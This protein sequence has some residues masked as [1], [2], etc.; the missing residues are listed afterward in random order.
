MK[1]TL[2]ILLFLATYIFANNDLLELSHKD[3]ERI[4]SY[5]KK[6]ENEELEEELKKG[7]NANA[8]LSNFKKPRS[9][10]K[11]ATGLDNKE[12][13]KL[14]LKYGA[15]PMPVLGHYIS[16]DDLEMVEYLLEKCLKELLANGIYYPLLMVTIITLLISQLFRLRQVN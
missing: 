3:S 12:A 11:I 5:L 7:L 10:V 6:F 2:L 13:T 15:N 9:L 16:R 4:Y 14:L 1:K 8:T